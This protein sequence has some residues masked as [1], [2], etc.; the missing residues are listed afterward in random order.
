M[1]LPFSG[2]SHFIRVRVLPPGNTG[3][4]GSNAKS[5]CSQVSVV[6]QSSRRISANGTLLA[7]RI[8]IWACAP[9]MSFDIDA[10]MAEMDEKMAA[11]TAIPGWSVLSEVA[12]GTPS[13][14]DDAS[15][16]F[17]LVSLHTSPS[18]P[19]PT[20]LFWLVCLPIDDSA[21]LEGTNAVPKMSYFGSVGGYCP[22]VEF[23]LTRPTFNIPRL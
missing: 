2:I 14:V 8:A 18:F 17:S 4:I 12:V 15:F 1:P 6:V 21:V 19:Y 22:P 20:P 3:F 11:P 9:A 16:G 5:I 23:P 10:F 7:R 13:R